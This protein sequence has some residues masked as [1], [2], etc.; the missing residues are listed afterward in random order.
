MN[1]KLLQKNSYFSLEGRLIAIFSVA[2]MLAIATTAL[3]F[4]QVAEL[5]VASIISLLLSLLL[6][7]AL[8]RRFIR[9]I[10]KI[11]DA[12]LDSMQSFKDSDFSVSIAS[13]RNDE[14]G[15]LV[16]A[17]NEIRETLRRERLELNQ[18]EL[19]LDTVNQTTP[20][21]ML[22]VNDK[23]HI[24]YSNMSAR[25]LLRQG[26]LLEGL[27]FSE[28]IN[29]SMPFLE[30]A[31]RQKADGLFSVDQQ[32]EVE[33]YHVSCRQFRLHGQPHDLYLIREMTREFSR[34]EV[35]TWKKVIQVI[36]HELNNSLAPISSL[37]H[38]GQLILDTN[39]TESLQQLFSTIEERATYLKQFI[40][41]YTQF[42][43]LPSPNIETVDLADYIQSII[44]MTSA[45]TTSIPQNTEV[46]FDPAQIQQV[47]INLLKN[48]SESGSPS[49]EITLEATL[50][51]N[52]LIIQVNDKGKGMSAEELHN[53]LLPFYS[54]KP[55]GSG[56]GLP[57]CREIIEAHD[58]RIQLNNRQG[59]GLNVCLVIPQ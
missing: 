18:K 39:Q 49:D 3:V 53:G 35:A 44:D 15:Q 8:L 31:L 20:I 7:I 57:L 1:K 40:D 50:K 52:Q 51:A 21:A 32:G 36:S 28:L 19:L 6:G 43:K 23:Q 56:L 4:S 27:D 33:T 16:D 41:G 42:A 48:A 29:T 25:K 47:L 2:I 54:T 46:R 5:W 24:T 14:L 26:K 13:D 11:F 59:G 58:G 34:Q 30:N 38:S 55:T 9:P 37:A 12:L 10:N 17:H 45:Q 22:L